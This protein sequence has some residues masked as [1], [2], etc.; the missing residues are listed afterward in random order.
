MTNFENEEA[1]ERFQRR[2]ES[3]GISAELTRQGIEDGDVVHIGSF[4]LVW[5]EQEETGEPDRKPRRTARQRLAD[6]TVSPDDDMG[7]EDE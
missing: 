3:T 4:E 7:P 5:G 6:R 2:L 1:V